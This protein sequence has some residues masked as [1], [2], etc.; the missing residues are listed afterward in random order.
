[1]AVHFDTDECR[2]HDLGDPAEA[3]A[4][5]GT[6]DAILAA[7]KAGHETPRGISASAGLSPATVRQAVRRMVQDGVLVK[8]A[9]GRYATREHR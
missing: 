7:L 8:S 9:H 4:P 5:A 2:W 1:M 3:F 6:R